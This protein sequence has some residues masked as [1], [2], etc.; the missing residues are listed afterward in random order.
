MYDLSLYCVAVGDIPNQ[1]SLLWIPLCIEIE[2][3]EHSFIGHMFTDDACNRKT[4][5]Q[6]QSYIGNESACDLSLYCVT[7][8]HILNKKPLLSIPLCIEM[9]CL[10]HSFIGHMFTDDACNRK[11]LFQK[12]SYIGNESACDLSLYCVTAGH[13]LNQ[14]PLLSIPLCIEIEC[15]EHSFIGHMF[16]DDACNRK[17]LFQ[18]QS[19][20]GNES[21]CDLSL[22]CVT[23]GH[24]L[25]KKPLLSI[26]LCIEMKCLG[27]SFICHMFIDDVCNWGTLLQEQSYIGNESACDLSLYCV[28]AGH[29]LNQKLLL[30]ISLCIE[31]KCLGHSFICH[32]FLNDACNRET[33]LQKQYNTES[34]SGYD[35]SRYCR[36][37][38]HILYQ[39]PPISISLCIE[40]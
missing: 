30:S 15:F 2:C 39:K 6:K 26:P 35:L 38:S 33:L 32:V 5:F 20:I 1:K 21:A 37:A 36:V 40:I 12:Q 3:C 10:G 29:I 16:T 24:I 9:K 14:K 7:A 31:M 28:T 22:Y 4:L 17:T 13:I 11:T 34:E 8:G 18:K 19:Y 25:N 23:A 27:H